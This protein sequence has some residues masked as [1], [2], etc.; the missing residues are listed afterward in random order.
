[1]FWYEEDVKGLEHKQFTETPQPYTIFYG[2]SSIRLWQTLE[3][4][5]KEINTINL[6]FGGSTLAACAWFFERIFAP[7]QP[8]RIVIYA[9]DNDIGDGRVPEEVFIYYQELAVLIQKKY[10]SIPC[11]FISLKPSLSRWNLVHNL[12]HTNNL[13][14]NDIIKN[15][16][17]WHFINIFE[18]MIDE[19]GFPIKA[20][21]DNDG[22]HLSPQGYLLWKHAVQDAFEKTRIK[23]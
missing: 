7:Y 4:D 6:G 12:K 16:N 14:E 23:I 13:I 15:N 19:R 8:E 10:G 22:L 17:N 18:T 3:Y 5:F 2:S 9:G 21:L 11:F 20:Y 1:M